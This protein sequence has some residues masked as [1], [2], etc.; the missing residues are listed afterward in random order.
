MVHTFTVQSK[1]FNLIKEGKKKI[2]GRLNKSKFSTFKKGDE[3]KIIDSSNDNNI[4]SAKI[5]KIK[6]YISF[7]EYLSQEGLKR[8]LPGIKTIENGV[9]IYHKFYSKEQENEYGVLAIYIKK[10]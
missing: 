7:E 8:T 3:L 6:K 4:I 5:K 2:E 1:Y 10:H 9:N